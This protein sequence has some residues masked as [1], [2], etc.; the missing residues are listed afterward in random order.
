MQIT[1]KS[2]IPKI[3]SRIIATI[4]IISAGFFLLSSF[5]F[6]VLFEILAAL[7]VAGG[8]G[9]EWWLH[10]HPAGRRKNEK[11]EHHKLESRFI[12]MVALGVAME[13][14][15]LGNSIREG[16]KLEK[17]VVQIGTTNAQLVA[18]NLVLRSNVVALEWQTIEA[19]TN[20]ARIDPINLPIKSMVLEIS[21]KIWNPSD[22]NPVD[23]EAALFGG[24]CKFKTK[25]GGDIAILDCKQFNNIARAIPLLGQSLSITNIRLYTMSFNWP[26]NGVSTRLFSTINEEDVSTKSFDSQING[27]VI[28][29]PDSGSSLAIVGGSCVLTINGSIRR[30]FLIPKYFNEIFLINT[31]RP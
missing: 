24:F 29:V 12:A 25:Q 2:K 22:V 15:A 27:L 16:V 6:W 17:E 26:G 7:L 31:N 5:W 19:K 13:V 20:I 10:H 14:F 30:T 11:D 1:T 4:A 28:S 3:I 21:L 8:C 23:S 9:G 18:D